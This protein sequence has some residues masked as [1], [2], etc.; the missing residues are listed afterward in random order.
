MRDGRG[1]DDDED[2]CDICLEGDDEPTSIGNRE[3]DVHGRDQHQSEGVQRGTAE[4]VLLKTDNGVQDNRFNNVFN[5]RPVDVPRGVDP[6]STKAPNG[7]LEV[8]HGGPY[9]PAIDAQGNADCQNGQFG[10]LRG[11]LGKGRYPPH[12]P[13]PGDDPYYTQFNRNFAGGSHNVYSDNSPGLAGTTFTGVKNLRS[14]P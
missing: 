5:D 11:P 10:Y 13:V 3:A 2:R 12:G 4:R 6:I 14:V 7:A 9:F 1:S 8:F